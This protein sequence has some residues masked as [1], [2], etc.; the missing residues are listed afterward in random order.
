MKSF[1]KFWTFALIAIVSLSFVSCSDDSDSPYSSDIVGTWKLTE[2]KTSQSGSYISWPF[3]ATYASF[4]S[5]GTYYGRGYFGYG[6]GTWKAKGNKVSTY[7]DDELFITYEILSVSGNNAELK[8]IIDG[9]AIWIKC[10][11]Q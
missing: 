8:M 3:E 1:F 10:K 6:S 9:E 11:K 7:V 5:D 4:N 2:V